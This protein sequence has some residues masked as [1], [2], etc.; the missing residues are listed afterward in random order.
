MIPGLLIEF[1]HLTNPEFPLTLPLYV[2]E[3]DFRR[4]RLRH[5]TMEGG[6]S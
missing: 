2:G 3:D 6:F 4:Q 1:A 5:P